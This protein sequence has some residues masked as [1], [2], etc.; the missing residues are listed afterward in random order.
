M[1]SRSLL[2]ARAGQFAYAHLACATVGRPCP[3]PQRTDRAEGW[4]DQVL[5]DAHYLSRDKRAFIE[6]EP[7]IDA[8][9]QGNRPS[10]LGGLLSS[11]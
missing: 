4:V 8:P 10:R 2:E 5:N 6:Y 3:A 7:E 11:G 1:A 9:T